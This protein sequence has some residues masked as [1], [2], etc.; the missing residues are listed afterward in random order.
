MIPKHPTLSNKGG[1]TNGVQYKALLLVVE[2]GQDRFM[3]REHVITFAATIF[4]VASGAVVAAI[5]GLATDGAAEHRP[6]WIGFFV[7]AA[8]IA[9]ASGV[10]A[11]IAAFADKEEVER[12]ERRHKMIPLVGM[13]ICGVGLIGLGAWYFWPSPQAMHSARTAAS[14]RS[15]PT[16]QV[17]AAFSPA[18]P[19]AVAAHSIGGQGGALPRQAAPP[20]PAFHAPAPT[21]QA[22]PLRRLIAYEPPQIDQTT[23]TAGANTDFFLRVATTFIR[24]VGDDTITLSIPRF[25]VTFDGQA[26]FSAPT[27]KPLVLQQTQVATFQARPPE[28]GII[29]P[30]TAKLLTIDLEVDYDTIPKTGVRRSIRHVEYDVNFANGLNSPPLLNSPRITDADER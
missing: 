5:I 18:P 19:Q 25:D 17:E 28:P 30:R 24:N 16:S 14:V 22:V 27:E 2:S 8:I 13:I 1:S 6:F 7:A 9:I 10:I 26:A 3:R 29:I 11:C 4:G 12:L 15:A 21:A 20:E 23:V